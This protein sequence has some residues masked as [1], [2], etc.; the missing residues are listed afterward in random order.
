NPL[1]TIKISLSNIREGLAG[2]LNSEQEKII[3]LCYGV[4][5]R[6][7][8]LIN[9]LLDL[10]KIE[11]GMIDIKRRLC[12]LTEILDKQLNEFESIMEQKHIKLN[13]EI[14]QRSLSLWADEDKISEVINNLLSNAIKYT[15]E[16]GTIA[17]KVDYLEGFVR[18]EC[19]DTGPGIPLDKIDKIFNKFERVNI[20]KEGTGLG[21]SISKD[22][23]EM[24]KGRI[25]VENEP[26]GGSKFVVVLP[27][28]LR[29]TKR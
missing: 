21:L 3:E 9:D 10:H 25:W 26:N 20:T 7:G 29:K 14:L 16:G 22:I 17:L 4:L 15:P 8:R 23:V 6:M 2:K 27:T 1:L 28:D 11:A 13:K 24:H 5:E 12:N 18:L 19:S